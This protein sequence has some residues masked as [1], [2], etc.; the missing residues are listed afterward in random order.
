MDRQTRIAFTGNGR[1]KVLPDG[2]GG[3][4]V[5]LDGNQRWV[6]Y[7]SNP[8]PAKLHWRIKLDTVH[9]V[10]LD[11]VRKARGLWT[12]RSV[13]TQ[14]M[15]MG[16]LFGFLGKV[17]DNR[18]AIL[19][20][21]TV[22]KNRSDAEEQATLLAVKHGVEA[23]VIPVLKERPRGTV[24]LT[25]GK[26]TFRAKDVIWITPTSVEQTIT[27]HDV[28]YG[29][30][31][32]WHNREDRQYRGH[33]Y[34]TV[35]S[36]GQLAVAN[37][38]VAEALLKGL[39]PA[40]IYP[41]SPMNAL[42]AQAVT[43]RGELLAKIGHRHL[44]DPYVI[45]GDVHCQVYAGVHKETPRTSL[46]VTETR[47][48]M[49]FSKSG[50][51]DTVYCANCGGHTEHNE[52]VWDMQ[53]SKSLRGKPDGKTGLANLTDSA[54][55]AWLRRKHSSYCANTPLGGR[56]YRWSQTVSF[57]QIT[58]HMQAGGYHIDDVTDLKVLKRGVSGRV[59]S[60][61]VV[62]TARSTRVDGELNIRKALG[63]LK[64]SMF[65]FDPAKN[66]AGRTTGYTFQGGG[67]GHGVGMCQTGAIAMATQ[68]HSYANILSFYYNGAQV[69]R[70]Y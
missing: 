60:L 55:R 20:S 35:D 6:A 38:V 39:V 24:V 42:K 56:N 12:K 8:T 5:V 62:G 61:S 30:G 19:A 28:E 4:E 69:E 63:G 64:S 25:D 34:F 37:M 47:G 2:P 70:I 27:V 3:S 57:D 16:S 58:E 68:K 31:F 9:V 13:A 40:E 29:R 52:N 32:S 43:A 49:L 45:C 23:Q 41:T 7:V 50:L 15:E 36:N 21:K 66:S 54:M 53:P 14:T 17:L 18:K 46:A 67:F 33:L 48:E 11:H 26:V 22:F 59:L 51:V 10:D 1:I 44:A 65:V